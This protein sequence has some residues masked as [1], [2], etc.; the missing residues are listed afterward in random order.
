MALP[1]EELQGQE[2]ER[3]GKA[4]VSVDVNEAAARVHVEVAVVGLRRFRWRLRFFQFFIQAA[5]LFAPFHLRVVDSDEQP[6]LLYCPYCGHDNAY[7]LP[8]GVMWP[9]CKH[10]GRQFMVRDREVVKDPGP[11]DCG[12]CGY[13]EPYG[14][15]PECGCPVHDPEDGA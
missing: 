15:V 13:C 1:L 7:A 5:R 9:R 6:C 11:C 2:R 12:G 3:L 4:K 10:C 8:S 14:W